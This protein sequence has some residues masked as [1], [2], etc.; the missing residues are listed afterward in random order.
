[1]AMAAAVAKAPTHEFEDAFAEPI[2]QASRRI[3]MGRTCAARTEALALLANIVARHEF[4][5]GLNDE[6]LTRATRAVIAATL[7]GESERQRALQTEVRICSTGPS[8]WLG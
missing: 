3:R 4:L 5:R 1:M 8:C 7:G 2:A 6:R